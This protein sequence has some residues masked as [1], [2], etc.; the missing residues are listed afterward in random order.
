MRS[1]T[2]ENISIETSK[3]RICTK[4]IFFLLVSVVPSDEIAL[5]RRRM[6]APNESREKKTNHTMYYIISSFI[7]KPLSFLLLFRFGNY[8]KSSFFSLIMERNHLR[9]KAWSLCNE[10]LHVIKQLA[11]RI[12]LNAH[13]KDL[14][15]C[16]REGSS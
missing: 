1:W 5:K 9:K 2:R 8:Q 7:L 13:G 14:L 10:S 12:F 16:S 3:E 4:R 15:K 11:G 6:N